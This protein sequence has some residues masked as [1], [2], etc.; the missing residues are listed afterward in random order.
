MYEAGPVK[1]GEI[2]VNQFVAYAN[3]LIAEQLPT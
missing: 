1:L 3:N 2:D